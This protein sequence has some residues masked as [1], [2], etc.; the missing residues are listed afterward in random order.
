MRKIA[1]FAILIL[2]FTSCKFFSSQKV[3]TTDLVNQEMKSMN[4][5][6]VDRYPLFDTCDETASKARQKMCFESALVQHVYQSLSAA[7]IVVHTQL[8][9]TVN[10]QFLITKEGKLQ[11]LK[12]EKDSLVN[13]Q[14]PKLDSIVKG[15]IATLPQI[16]PALKRDIPVTTK[17]N[18]PLV[19]HVD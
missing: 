19:I 8:K 10:I 7:N 18:L 12:I 3:S 4:W 11:V 16:H 5:N 2:S 15:S 9:D 1:V 17:C 13:A 14:I 6:E